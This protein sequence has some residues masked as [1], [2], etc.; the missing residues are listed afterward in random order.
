[1]RKRPRHIRTTA[2]PP[3]RYRRCG[4]SRSG[5]PFAPGRSRLV[6]RKVLGTSAAPPGWRGMLAGAKANRPQSLSG[7]GH[8]SL[9]LHA[10]PE[11]LGAC[12]WS[13]RESTSLQRRGDGLDM[14]WNDKRVLV[15]GGAGFIGSHVTDVLLGRGALVTVLDDFST[16]FREF[17]PPREHL[18]I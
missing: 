18:R 5:G 16:G 6:R 11:R 1:M 15:T 2:L 7:S 14:D 9:L 4:F 13:R 3:A 10:S 8:S 12:Y 17:V